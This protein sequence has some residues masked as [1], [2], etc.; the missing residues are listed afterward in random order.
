MRG[1]PTVR[2]SC[3]PNV[4]Q[5]LRK[6]TGLGHIRAEEN[7]RCLACPLGH[8][9][10][11]PTALNKTCYCCNCGVASRVVDAIF[12]KNCGDNT[13]WSPTYLQTRRQ[14]PGL[15]C[16]CCWDC[17]PWPLND[18]KVRQHH[19]PVDAT[20]LQFDLTDA[21]AKFCHRPSVICHGK[22]DF[23]LSGQTESLVFRFFEL[24]D[25]FPWLQEF[26]FGPF[27]KVIH[28]LRSGSLA[29]II[30]KI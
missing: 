25:Y 22:H 28:Q 16:R 6:N 21:L 3:T 15:L 11:Q 29:G 4:G 24:L 10:A 13:C 7:Q 26:P 1:P 8:G 18:R 30:F 17:E 19:T 14:G 9:S 23:A 2:Q 12:C 27:V 20:G 5:R